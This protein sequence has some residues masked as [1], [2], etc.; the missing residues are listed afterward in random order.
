[1]AETFQTPAVKML[2]HVAK[3]RE[4]YHRAEFFVDNEYHLPVRVVA[5]DWPPFEGDA[6]KLIAE[7]TYTKVRINVGLSD[8]DFDV[9]LLQTASR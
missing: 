7:F 3:L 2:L 6:P 5:Y 4:L 9:E 1:M 8:A